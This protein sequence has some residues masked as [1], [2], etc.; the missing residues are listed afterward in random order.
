MLLLAH[1]K[2]GRHNNHLASSQLH[3]H[4]FIVSDALFIYSSDTTISNMRARM[5][6]TDLAILSAA[7]VQGYGA[8]CMQSLDLC[9]H[10]SRLLVMTSDMSYM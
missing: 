8:V 6:V 3:A 10:I 4:V 1:D 5:W 2:A 9:L 7:G